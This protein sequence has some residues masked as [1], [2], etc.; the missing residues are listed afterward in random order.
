M[1]RLVAA[2]V[3]GVGVSVREDPW[4]GMLLVSLYEPWWWR[5]CWPRRSRWRK[6]ALVAA[7]EVTADAPA[8][9]VVRVRWA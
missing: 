6:R 2:A 4:L 9:V 5:A 7:V 8:G 1:T 3:P